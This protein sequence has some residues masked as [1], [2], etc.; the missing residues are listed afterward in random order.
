MTVGQLLLVAVTFLGG[1][2][3]VFE[4]GRRIGRTSKQQTSMSDELDELDEKLGEQFGELERRLDREAAMRERER[5][6]LL[7]WLEELT[8]ALLSEGYDVERPESV[9]ENINLARDELSPDN[10]SD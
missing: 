2:G 9:Q 6:V 10:V 1:L 7:G 5:E 4:M 3:V 8:K